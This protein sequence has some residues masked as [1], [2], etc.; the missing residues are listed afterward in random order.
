MLEDYQTASL[1]IQT[2]TGTGSVRFKV[3][4]STEA[5]YDEL[6]FLIDGE[7]KLRLSGENS[8]IDSGAFAVTAGL[9]T[10]EWRYSKDG[11]TSTGEDAVWLDDIEIPLDTDG[12]GLLDSEDPDPNRI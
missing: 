1:A 4:T 5:D 6:V 10:F 11:G 7:E 3:R 9:H 2:E 12:D 8:W